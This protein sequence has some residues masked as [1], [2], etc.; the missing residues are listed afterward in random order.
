MAR[1]CASDDCRRERVAL[2]RFADLAA[3]EAEQERA[4][5]RSWER[6]ADDTRRALAAANRE[7]RR[8]NDAWLFWLVVAGAWLGV[9]LEAIP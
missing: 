9:I 8:S 6:E 4:R 3:V 5:A 2:R 7:P 1:L